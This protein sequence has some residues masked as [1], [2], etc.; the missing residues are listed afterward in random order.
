MK[1]NF[2]MELKVDMV[3]Y[4]SKVE[5]NIKEISLMENSK[6]S[7]SSDRISIH[8]KANLRMDNTMAK[9]NIFGHQD[10]FIKVNIKK[11]RSM[12]TEYTKK[13]MVLVMKEAG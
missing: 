2:I 4:I 1:A 12:A 10:L 5:I 13:L 9:V 8:M 6:E 3:K 11:V 7:A